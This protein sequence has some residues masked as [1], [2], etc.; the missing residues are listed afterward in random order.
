[1]RISDTRVK[2]QIG[3]F[4]LL[5]Y[6]LLI[7]SPIMLKMKKP[8]MSAATMVEPTGVPVTIEIR[9]PTAAQVIDTTTEQIVTDLKLLNTRMADKAG[10]ITSA[11]I[12]KAP[13]RFMASTITTAITIARI[14]LYVFALTPVAV[15]KSSSKVTANILL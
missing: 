2:T 15:E 6:N 9:K 3:I 13:T 8:A 7:I 12:N 5:F 11:E 14:R 1:M 4:S 10:N